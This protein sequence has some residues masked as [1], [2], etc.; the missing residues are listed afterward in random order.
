ME[1][2]RGAETFY[3]SLHAKTL[4]NAHPCIPLLLYIKTHSLQ[5]NKY[6]EVSSG[7]KLLPSSLGWREEDAKRDDFE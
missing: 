5:A 3:P 6:Y 2:I 1:I 4:R 7:K